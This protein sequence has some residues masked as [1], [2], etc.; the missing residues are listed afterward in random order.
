MLSVHSVNYAGKLLFSFCQPYRMPCW[1]VQWN[2]MARKLIFRN[3][4]RDSEVA[5]LLPLYILIVATW[6]LNRVHHFWFTRFENWA[7][8]PFQ[9]KMWD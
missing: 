3:V 2:V 5:V 4:Q 7:Y 1:R 9:V 6:V 8:L